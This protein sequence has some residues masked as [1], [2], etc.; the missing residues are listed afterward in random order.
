MS[1]L[2]VHRHRFEQDW[3]VPAEMTDH[4]SSTLN[5]VFIRMGWLRGVQLGRSVT[6]YFPPVVTQ[7]S[8]SFSRNTRHFLG[9]VAMRHVRFVCLFVMLAQYR[10]QRREAIRQ[11]FQRPFQTAL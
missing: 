4:P 11:P 3:H 5:R 6:E 1:P 7:P 10:P 2:G 8:R 9:G